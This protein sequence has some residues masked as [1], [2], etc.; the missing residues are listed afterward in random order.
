MQ[1]E[2]FRCQSK[3]R[4]GAGSR[5]REHVVATFMGKNWE[6][7]KVGTFMGGNVAQS[8]VE[9]R[10]IHEWKFGTIMSGDFPHTWV[11]IWHIHG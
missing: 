10:N 3:K 9:I 6:C 4:A 1:P 7:G 5:V 2:D 11:E 8:W